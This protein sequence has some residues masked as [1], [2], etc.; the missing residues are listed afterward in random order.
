MEITI[1]IGA[2]ELKGIL[3]EHI[4][5]KG[6]KIRED[7]ILFVIGKEETVTENSKKIKHAFIGC[8]IQFER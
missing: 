6:F 8:E 7:D 5:T 4:K 2:D 1:G 3:V